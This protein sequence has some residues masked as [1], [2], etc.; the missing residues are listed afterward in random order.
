MKPVLAI[1]LSLADGFDRQQGVD[2]GRPAH[3][4]R[5]CQAP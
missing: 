3:A 4:K 1:G 2:T 5:S